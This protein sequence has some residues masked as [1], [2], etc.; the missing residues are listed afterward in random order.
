MLRVVFMTPICYFPVLVCFVS[1][2]DVRMSLP[3]VGVFLIILVSL[4]SVQCLFPVWFV[5]HI[6]SKQLV[7]QKP[8]AS[9]PTLTFVFMRTPTSSRA[10]FGVQQAQWSDLD[11]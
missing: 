2:L 11:M 9:L 6:K 5:V 10:S 7:N 3:I 1:V 8:S 4:S